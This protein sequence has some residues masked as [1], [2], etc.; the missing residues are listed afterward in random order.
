M[1]L[2]QPTFELI[3]LLIP[4]F[5]TI[6]LAF[7]AVWLAL[8]RYK[9]EKTWER[10]LTAYIDVCV[11]LSEMRKVVGVW[12]DNIEEGRKFDKQWNQNHRDRYRTAR[13]NLD[14]A[15]A[16]SDLLLPKSTRSI[17]HRLENAISSS[18]I[19]DQWEAFNYEY[20]LIDDALVDLVSQGRITLGLE[21]ARRWWKRK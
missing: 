4:A 10:Q 1:I 14:I 3:K 19:E 9:K 12:A 18:R 5:I 6:L 17:L 13:Q 15:V 8:G 16:L 21:P 2:G 11:A 7:V 20:S